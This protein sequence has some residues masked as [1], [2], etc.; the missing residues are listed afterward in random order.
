MSEAKKCAQC[1][2]EKPI[3]DFSKSYKGLC[4]SCVAE[5][6]RL[7]RK[8]NMAYGVSEDL[9]TAYIGRGISIP[10]PED[11]TFIPPMRFQAS[12]AA[13][14]G[15]LASGIKRGVIA[16]SIELADA[17]INELNKKKDENNQ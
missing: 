17:L 14:Q 1:A 3:E 8:I 15:L 6:E 12:V 10:I 16:R 11:A 4:K 2:Q 13:M 7:K 5:R 9:P